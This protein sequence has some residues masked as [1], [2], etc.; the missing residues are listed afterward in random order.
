MNRIVAVAA[1]GGGGS[2]TIEKGVKK[3]TFVGPCTFNV[4]NMIFCEMVLFV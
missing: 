3:R 2:R 4:K 1:G